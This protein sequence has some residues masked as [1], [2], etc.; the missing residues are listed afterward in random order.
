[1]RKEPS[2]VAEQKKK[3]WI[4]FVMKHRDIFEKIAKHEKKNR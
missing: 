1:M 3:E 4:E 2:P